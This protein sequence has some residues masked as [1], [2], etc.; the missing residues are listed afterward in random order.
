M[1]IMCVKS[2]RHD[3]KMATVDAQ[4]YCGNTV[5]WARKVSDSECNMACAGDKTVKCGAGN[6]NE[7]YTQAT[8]VEVGTP[9]VPPASRRWLWAHHMVGN[10]S[11]RN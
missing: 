9:A 10:V 7:V 5:D 11:F 4:C 2:F 3:Q 1:E 8:N 6:R